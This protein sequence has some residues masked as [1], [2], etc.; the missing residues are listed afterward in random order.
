MA[1]K[2]RPKTGGRKLGTLNKRTERERRLITLIDANDDDINRRVIEEAKTG[3]N[4]Q[5][6]TL[7]YKFLRP[8]APKLNSTPLNVV[9]P[10]T[11]EDV[12]ALSGKLAIEVLAGALDIDVAQVTAALLKNVESSI[13]GFDLAQLLERLKT[14]RKP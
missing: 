5:A 8:R 9:E 13:V 14:E 6:T 12:R 10:R 2:G 4:W 11:V 1:G 7:Y 3:A